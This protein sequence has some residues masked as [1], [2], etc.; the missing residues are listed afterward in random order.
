MSLCLSG[1]GQDRRSTPSDGLPID[2][3]HCSVA[4]GLAR[5]EKSRRCAEAMGGDLDP[6][7]Q[8]RANTGPSR[9]LRTERGAMQ[10]QVQIF[11]QAGA[12]GVEI[13]TC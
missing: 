6:G 13:T 12:A 1:I 3:E 4:A 5:R 2:P 11:R 8:Q 7:A 9:L 10:R